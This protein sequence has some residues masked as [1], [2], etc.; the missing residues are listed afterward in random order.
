M[1]QSPLSDG[2]AN[3]SVSDE[4]PN[5]A[6]RSSARIKILLIKQFGL[7]YKTPSMARL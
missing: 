3:R 2:T 7:I 4:Q 1:S 5:K 6:F